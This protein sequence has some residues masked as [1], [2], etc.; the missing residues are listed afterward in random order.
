MTNTSKPTLPTGQVVTWNDEKTSTYYSNLMAF[1][2][3][4]F[5]I[6]VIFGEVGQATENEV[7]G[8]GKARIILSPEQALNLHKLIGAAVKKYVAVNGPLRTAGAVDLEVFENAWGGISIE[9]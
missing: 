3:T 8:I 4:P 6:T 9:S 7:Q 1:S 5:D 2:M